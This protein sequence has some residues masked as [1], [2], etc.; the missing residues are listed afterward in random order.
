MN[1]IVIERYIVSCSTAHPVK[2]VFDAMTSFIR[3][4]HAVVRG[5]S[6]KDEAEK[7]FVDYTGSNGKDMLGKFD[8]MVEE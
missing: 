1:A 2:E 5:A 8:K 4:F 3:L 6:L 7:S